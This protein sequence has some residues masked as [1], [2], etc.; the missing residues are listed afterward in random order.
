M[1]AESLGC[2]PHSRCCSRGLSLLSECWVEPSWHNEFPFPIEAAPLEQEGRL[3]S[4][5]AFPAEEQRSV[6]VTWSVPGLS[7]DR[8]NKGT[9]REKLC[10]N[11]VGSI[12]LP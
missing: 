7:P 2:L 8:P 1:R 12:L 4:C 11:L 6:S 10:T 3:P 9:A 5:S